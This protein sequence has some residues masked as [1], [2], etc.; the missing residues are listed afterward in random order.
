MSR[1]RAFPNPE[2]APNMVPSEEQRHLV[3]VLAG[4]GVPQM[5]IARLLNKHGGIDHRTLKKHFAV[6]LEHGREA[7]IASLKTDIVKAA[8]SGSVR[9]QTWL[10]ERLDPANF[11]R[12]YRPSPEDI[13][14]APIADGAKVE[15]YLP[16]NSRSP[17]DLSEVTHLGVP[18]VIDAIVERDPRANPEH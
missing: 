7:L 9:A 11:G 6:E 15:I 13:P 18:P 5:T 4:M 12:I 2:G 14:T 16:D 3:Q 10:L 1:V 17:S 8:K